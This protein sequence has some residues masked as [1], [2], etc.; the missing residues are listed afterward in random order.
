MKLSPEVLSRLNPY[1]QLELHQPEAGGVMLG[2]RILGC[3]DVVIDE[4]TPPMEGD[5]RARLQFHRAPARHQSVIDARW[6]ESRGTCLYLGEWHTHPEPI[7]TPSSI[8]LEGWSRRLKED[9]FDGSSLFFLIVG[10]ERVA[11]WEGFRQSRHLVPLRRIT[12]YFEQVS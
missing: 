6:A 12:S 11:L 1:R 7:P 3:D 9:Q 8:D 4:V 2:R 5:S 10:M